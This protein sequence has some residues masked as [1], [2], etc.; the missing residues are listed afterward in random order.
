MIQIT[1][2]FRSRIADHSIGGNTGIEQLPS[3]RPK[4][5]E[6]LERFMLGFPG[7]E[8][9]EELK[10][11]LAGGLA[12][13]AI[14]PRNFR[15]VVELSRLTRAI[16]QAAARPVLIGIDQEGG[17]K[18][19]LGEPFTP[20][21][22][23]AE[24]GRLADPS[25]VEKLARAMAHELRAAGVNL[26]FAP[27][28]DLA[29]NPN[30]PVTSGRSF[31]S[32]PHHVAQM[33]CAFLRGLQAEGVLACAKHFPGHGDTAVDPHLDLPR[34]DGTRERLMAQELVPFSSA[35]KAGVQTIMTAHILIPRIDSASPS[36]L[37]CELLQSILRKQLAFDGIILA[38]DLGMGAIARHYKIGEGVVKT[39]QAG[40]D[41]AML[42]HDWTIV[43][44]ALEAAAEALSGTVHQAKIDASLTAQSRTRIERLRLRL[45]EIEKAEAPPLDVIG[46][47]QHRTLAAE[48]RARIDEVKA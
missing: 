33:G 9:S 39:L 21:P 25:L 14:Y 20:W 19:S 31:G 37:S 13:V 6:L 3:T 23:P 27:M 16:R 35:I 26:N 40:T 47:R 30:S 28:L 24:L 46:C 5:Q 29:T 8:L 36:S 22:S 4:S 41:I 1:R 12:G 15:D 38:D 11:L 32:E 45:C 44:P 18:F 17:T 34:F 43:A 7:R 42:C 2:A 48:I 10:Q